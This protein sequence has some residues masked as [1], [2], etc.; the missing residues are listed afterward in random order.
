MTKN[1]IVLNVDLSFKSRTHQGRHVN[2]HP[3]DGVDL[4]QLG[5]L[6]TSIDL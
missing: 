5:F 6:L 3:Q 2:S 1:C 4:C